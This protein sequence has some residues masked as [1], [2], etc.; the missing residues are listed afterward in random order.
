V[1][2]GNAITGQEPFFAGQHEVRDLK[3]GPDGWIYLI[4]RNES[5][6]LRVER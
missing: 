3:Q 4:S 5:R 2:S 6:I 1:L